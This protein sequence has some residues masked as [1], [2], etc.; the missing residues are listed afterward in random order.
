[1]AV[2]CCS[3]PAATEA[4]AGVTVIEVSTGAVTV[5]IADPLIVPEVA[6]IV[7]VPCIKAVAKP[8]LFT[9][10]TESVDE[11]Q[12]AVLVRFWVVPLL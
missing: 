1:M 8:L 2:N 7:A 10:A 3:S 9:V 5:S 11:L 6:V 12:A 4:D